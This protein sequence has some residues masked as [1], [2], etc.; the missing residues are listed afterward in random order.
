MN[1][2]QRFY[3][4]RF[5]QHHDAPKEFKTTWETLKKEIANNSPHVVEQWLCELDV[6]T[7]ALNPRDLLYLERAEGGIGGGNN[8]TDRQIRFDFDY[9]FRGRKRRKRM[10]WDHNEIILH[11]QP[12]ADG[13]CIWLPED[14]TPFKDAFSRV[15]V[16]HLGTEAHDSFVEIVGV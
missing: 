1:G 14:L 7:N 13:T 8:M 2:A 10:G 15:I 16:N 5:R 6:E 3:N 9:T 12:S 4:I 11:A